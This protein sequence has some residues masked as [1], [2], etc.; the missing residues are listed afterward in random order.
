[1]VATIT[2]EERSSLSRFLYRV[3]DD[4]VRSA[5]HWRQVYFTHPPAEF[6]DDTTTS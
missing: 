5:E 2:R 4:P 6:S 3:S 1:M